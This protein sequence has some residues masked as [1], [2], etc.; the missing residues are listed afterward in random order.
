MYPSGNNV[1]RV[2][3]GAVPKVV[4]KK[5]KEIELEILKPTQS[6]N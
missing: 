2:K 1:S 3:S 4:Q 5:K 6:N